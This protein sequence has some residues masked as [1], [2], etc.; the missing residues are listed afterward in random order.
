MARSRSLG[1]EDTSL[2]GG[3]ASLSGFSLLAC[4]SSESSPFSFT[5]FYASM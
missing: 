4:S 3:G 5:A 1:Y 2:E